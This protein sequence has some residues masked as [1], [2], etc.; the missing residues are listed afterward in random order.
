MGVAATHYVVLG[1]ALKDKKK[2][3]AF[4]AISE[5]FLDFTEQYDDN[6]YKD[7]PTP[8]ESGI[9]M[10]VDG[11]CGEYIVV[12]KILSKGI[13]E[14]MPFTQMPGHDLAI[15]AVE[16][17]QE[18]L[19]VFREIRKIDEAMGTDFCKLPTQYLA[20]THWH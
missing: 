18:R 7:T 20:F 3:K 14:G 4:F 11:M 19:D 1:V 16:R 15:D 2:V 6:G 17:V 5:K 12:G 9:H 8:T 13:E 10:I